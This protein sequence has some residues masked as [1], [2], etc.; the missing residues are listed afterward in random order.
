MSTPCG[1]VTQWQEVSITHQKNWVFF[2]KYH[3]VL[4]IKFRYLLINFEVIFEISEVYKSLKLDS[5]EHQL[6]AAKIQ[7]QTDVTLTVTQVLTYNIGIRHFCKVFFRKAKV[8]D[9]KAIFCCQV[10]KLS[11]GEGKLNVTE[12]P[13]G[14]LLLLRHIKI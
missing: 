2:S 5:L 11:V 6:H 14:C 9:R 12:P 7:V 8:H 3:C 4:Q 10:V 1:P 13:R